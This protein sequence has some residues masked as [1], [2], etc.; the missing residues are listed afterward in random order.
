M[1]ARFTKWRERRVPF[2]RKAQRA[3]AFPCPCASTRQLSQRNSYA[4]VKGVT[5]TSLPALPPCDASS[6]EGTGRALLGIT[7]SLAE[8]CRKSDLSVI[9]WNPSLRAEYPLDSVKIPKSSYRS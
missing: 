5:L 6:C 8:I 9:K 3:S 2:H 1:K 7:A 4:V